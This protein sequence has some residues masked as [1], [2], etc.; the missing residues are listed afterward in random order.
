M[1]QI[2]VY[3][4]ADEVLAELG[5]DDVLAEADARRGRGEH[6]RLLDQIVRDVRGRC[7]SKALRDYLYEVTGRIV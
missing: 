3:V 1:P 6:G 7:D 5:D 2:S 4:D